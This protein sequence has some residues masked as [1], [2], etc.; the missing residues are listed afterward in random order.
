MKTGLLMALMVT[1]VLVV[2]NSQ[3]GRRAHPIYTP[4]PIMV[5]G[6]H[7]RA[8]IRRAIKRALYRR[9]WIVRDVNRGLIRATYYRGRHMATV[10]VRYSPRQVR[11]SYHR[12]E[13]LFYNPERGTIHKTYNGWVR[14][15]E[16]DIQVELGRL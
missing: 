14:N 16:R 15:M 10:N 9:K 1:M 2:P 8:T 5:Y 3:A 4:A 12:T 13:A 6:H 11:I 7:S